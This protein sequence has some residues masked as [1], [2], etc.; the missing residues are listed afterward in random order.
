MNDREGR[1]HPHGVAVGEV[2]GEEGDR[3]Q[4]KGRQAVHEVAELHGINA[5]LGCVCEWLSV[6]GHATHTLWQIKGPPGREGGG[7][8]CQE[9]KTKEC[10]AA[11]WYLTNSLP[12]LWT[13]GARNAFRVLEAWSQVSQDQDCLWETVSVVRPLFAGGDITKAGGGGQVVSHVNVSHILHRA[14]SLT[15]HAPLTYMVRFSSS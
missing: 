9:R 14:R 1:C 8:V 12:R 15:V 6:L 5:E 13:S 7:G 3:A 2:R 11:F 10:K 4:R